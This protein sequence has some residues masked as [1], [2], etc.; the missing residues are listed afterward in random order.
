MVRAFGIL[1]VLQ[2]AEGAGE[3]ED[4][5]PLIP[6]SL[7]FFCGLKPPC[8]SGVSQVLLL[9]YCGTKAAGKQSVAPIAKNQCATRLLLFSQAKIFAK[10]SSLGW[11]CL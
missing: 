2:A 9:L 7:I 4:C 11:H 6:L 10:Q 3:E 1:L 8:R 5:F